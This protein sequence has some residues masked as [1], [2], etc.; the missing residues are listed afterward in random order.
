MPD[1]RFILSS[2]PPVELEEIIDSRKYSNIKVY[3]D[4]KNIAVSLYLEEVARDIVSNSQHN[5]LDST[6]F[7]SVLCTLA[8]WKNYSILHRVGCDVYFFSD[9]GK[10]SYHRSILPSYKASRSISNLRDPQLYEDLFMVREKNTLLSES[11]VNRLPNAYFFNLKFLE[12]DFVPY[13]LITRCFP[14]EE[15]TLH[16][17]VSNDK[18][19]YQ[20]LNRENVV[21]IYTKNGTR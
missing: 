3:I 9:G 5:Y 17:V 14:D 1:P 18:D 11:I 4:F 15:D 6:I 21:Q 13:Y 2:R 10:S 20:N 8:W 19:M 7:Q 12:A 16:I